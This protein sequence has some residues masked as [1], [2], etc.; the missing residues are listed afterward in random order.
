M[1]NNKEIYY[2]PTMYTNKAG[3]TQNGNMIDYS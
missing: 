2:W 1:D 3:V